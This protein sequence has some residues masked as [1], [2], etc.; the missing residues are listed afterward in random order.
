[1]KLPSSFTSIEWVVV[2]QCRDERCYLDLAGKRG[3]CWEYQWGFCV[4]TE[5]ERTSFEPAWLQQISLWLA[6]MPGAI[7]DG[8]L[9]E[10][11]KLWLTRRYTH[12]IGSVELEAKLNQQ[13]AVTRWLAAHGIVGRESITPDAIGKRA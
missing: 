12:D 10:E 6:S 11:G 7:D 2:R 3:W 4:V 13:L 9:L 8:L 1:M 5:I